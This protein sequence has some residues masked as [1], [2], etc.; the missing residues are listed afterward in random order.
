MKKWI[1]RNKKNKKVNKALKLRVLQ[2]R[3]GGI[4]LDNDALLPWK[5]KRGNMEYLNYS[6]A[7]RKAKFANNLNNMSVNH[8]LI[9]QD[10]LSPMSPSGVV[11]EK[12]VL[13]LSNL[14]SVAEYNSFKK[15]TGEMIKS[16]KKNLNSHGNDSS[17]GVMDEWNQDRISIN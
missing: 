14:A 4:Y 7:E 9:G 16:S 8:Q 10:S 12:E 2:L 6:F 5:E 11:G 15:V 3:W 17:E 13:T 1:I